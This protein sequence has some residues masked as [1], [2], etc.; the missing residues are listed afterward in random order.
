MFF[1]ENEDE[2]EENKIDF[3]TAFALYNMMYR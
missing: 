1:F 3:L 2:N